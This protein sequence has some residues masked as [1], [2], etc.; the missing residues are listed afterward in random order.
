M[1]LFVAILHFCFQHCSLVMS[2]QSVHTDFW[3]NASGNAT[4]VR[5]KIQSIACSTNDRTGLDPSSENL[6][7]IFNQLTQFPISLSHIDPT[8]RPRTQPCIHTHH[9]NPSPHSHQGLAETGKGK[10]QILESWHI[11]QIKTNIMKYWSSRH[12]E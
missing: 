12:C 7:F 9:L 4:I 3:V 6:I 5:Q 8:P 2:F 10:Q 11:K 1:G